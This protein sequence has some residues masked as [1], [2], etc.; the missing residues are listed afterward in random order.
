MYRWVPWAQRRARREG[1][2]SRPSRGIS[3]GA[4]LAGLV[5][6]E[7]AVA[8]VMV[9]AAILTFGRLSEEQAYVRDYVF[10]PLVDIGTAFAEVAELRTMKPSPD[11]DDH[12][13][14]LVGRLGAFIDRYDRD[15]KIAGSRLPEAIRFR[16]TLERANELPLIDEEDAASRSFRGAL[17]SVEPGV[18]GAALLKLTQ[19]LVR[20]NQVNLHYVEIAGDAY[21]ARERSLWTTFLLVGLAGLVTAPLLG[22]SVRRAIVPRVR[23]MV[24]KVERFRELGVNVPVNET[25]GDELAVLARALDVSFAA[26]AHR[27]KD[28]ERF[29]AIAAHELKT[30]LTTLKGFAESALVHRNEPALRDRALTI[31]ARQSTR[32]GRLVHDLLWLARMQGEAFLFRPSPL[33]LAALTRR[34]LAEVE[35]T[36]KDHALRLEVRGETHI[37]GD[38]ELLEQTIW[39]LIFQATAFAPEHDAVGITLEGTEAQVRLTATARRAVDLPEDLSQLVEPF[40]VLQ[41]E[42]GAAP[43]STGLGLYLAREIARLHGGTVRVERPARDVVVFTLELGR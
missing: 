3:L 11:E 36:S 27:D 6:S 35:I 8:A 12:A 1:D 38:G 28:R 15:W 17:P 19:A 31:I 18:P 2:H 37:L 20:L 24:D 39:N 25:G 41:Y 29:L 16:A 10:A 43:R 13:R 21:V 22:L 23:R 34:V 26:I 42:G 7:L 40:A 32:L 30:P 4:R 9:T 33:D 5:L 14:Q